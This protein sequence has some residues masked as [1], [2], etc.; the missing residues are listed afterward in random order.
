[1]ALQTFRLVDPT[2]FTDGVV[3]IRQL[4]DV[5]PSRARRPRNS[6]A[7]RGPVLACAAPHGETI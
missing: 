5:H 3:T 2:S 6:S 4:T 1:M 7:R